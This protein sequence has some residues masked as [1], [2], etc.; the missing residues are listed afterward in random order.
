MKAEQA[1]INQRGEK[2]EEV[3]IKR[4]VG[5]VGGHNRPVGPEPVGEKEGRTDQNKEIIGIR[6]VAIAQEN[7][8]AQNPKVAGEVLDSFR[9]KER[10]E[11]T[12]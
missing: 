1:K 7:E 2:D 12:F 9:M 8:K 6:G 10:H 5:D 4:F 3:V 11:K